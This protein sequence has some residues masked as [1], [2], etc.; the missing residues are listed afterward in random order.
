M[1]A[2]DRYLERVH[3]AAFGRFFDK[4]VGPFAPG[5]NVVYGKNEAG[6]TTLNAFITGVLFGWDDA[7]GQKNVYKP[8]IA[9]RS[10]SLFFASRTADDMWE[11]SRTRN[12]DGPAFEPAAASALLGTVDK[13]TFQT[14]FA[15]TS[16]E[17]RSL[18]GASDMTARLLTAGSGTN[19]APAAALAALDARIA[20]FTSRAASADRSFVHLRAQEEACKE[21]LA[22]A[23]EKSDALKAEYREY[24]SLLDG[25]EGLAATVTDLNARIEALSA[26]RSEVERLDAAIADAERR[27]KAC[28]ADVCAAG[29]QSPEGKETPLMSEADESRALAVLERLQHDADRISHRVDAAHDAFVA[30]R[31]AEEAE[32][33]DGAP[34]AKVPTGVFSG[35]VSGIIGVVAGA[36]LLVLGIAGGDMLSAAAG[37]LVAGAGAACV[38]WLASMR[39]K[40][41]SSDAPEA[42]A[43]AAAE[44]ARRVLE[45]CEQEELM[46]SLRI[47]EELEAAGLADAHGSLT[48]ARSIVAV[49]RDRR[50]QAEER[51]RV[52]RDAAAARERAGRDYRAASERRVGLFA[53]CNIAPEQGIAALEQAEREAR[54][55]RDEATERMRASELRLGELRQAL[56]DGA[57]STEF[58]LLKTELAQINTRKDESAQ[59]LAELLLARRALEQAIDAWK[60]ESVPA[61]YRR[62]SELFALMTDGAWRELRMRDDG[63]LVAVDAVNK[64]REPR[65][66]STGT[67]QQMYLAL[68]IALLE[69]ADDIGAGLPV[70]A[71]DIL[72][73][74]DDERRIGAVK[75]LAELAR[76]RQ[77]LLFTCHKEIL[78][79]VQRTVSE[80]TVVAL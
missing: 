23:R 62:A 16:D 4:S 70:M 36:L 15:L 61:V 80:C 7:R 51:A 3:M 11:V 41:R 35:L 79:T 73:N 55:R 72:V 47:A 29:Q 42:A 10:G 66:L 5:F 69:S 30:A 60:S 33:A 68:R 19:A 78:H 13:G 40:G 64:A 12:V 57:L 9:R 28:E 58:D 8:E 18:E 44:Q 38:A 74:F 52:M 26:A 20:A 25:R 67:C 32:D 22:A 1:D 49:S 21:R 54:I 56:R 24:Q 37:V 76:T 75:A 17:L 31:A 77:V 59:E 53:T 6:K 63:T 27:L 34:Q 71:D 65:L 48:Q 14:V 50:T 2:Q 43:H 39:K 45:A 46:F